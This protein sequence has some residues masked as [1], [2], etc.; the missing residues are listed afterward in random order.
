MKRNK[1]PAFWGLACRFTDD[2]GK[3]EGVTPNA[4]EEEDAN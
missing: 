4:G 2:I 3:C 1:E